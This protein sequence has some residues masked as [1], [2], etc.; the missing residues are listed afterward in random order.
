MVENAPNFG[1]MLGWGPYLRD[2][3]ATGNIIRKAD[4]GIAVSVVDGARSTVISGN[5][6][7]D[8]KNG[9]IV[10]Y[11]WRER[12]SDDLAKDPGTW[13]HLSVTANRVS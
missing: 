11:R 10:G 6:L 5:I 7:S 1:M 2:V 8:V 13:P 3:A 12:A 9:A 4:V